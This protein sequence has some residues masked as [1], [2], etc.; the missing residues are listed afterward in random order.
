MR[1][2]RV[3]INIE[4][5]GTLDYTYLHVLHLPPPEADKRKA[6]WLCALWTYVDLNDMT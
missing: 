3:H 1:E 6:I 5:P 4:A 2:L